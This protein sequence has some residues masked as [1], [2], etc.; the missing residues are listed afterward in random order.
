[1]QKTNN[2]LSSLRKELGI[3]AKQRTCCLD[4]N[5]YALPGCLKIDE[6]IR[7]VYKTKKAKKEFERHFCRVDELLEE[8]EELRAYEKYYGLNI[9]SFAEYYMLSSLD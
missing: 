4:E 1:M 5:G 3:V 7:V 8:F 9:L 2:L 6:V